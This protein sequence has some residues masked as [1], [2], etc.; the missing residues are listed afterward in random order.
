MTLNRVVFVA[1]LF[2]EDY[3]G[4]A[5]LTS[6][7][8]IQSSPHSVV[9]IKAR[10][11]NVKTLEQYQN[12]YWIFGNFASLDFN[13]IPII[14]ANI[15]YA[16]LEY[17]YKF[18]NFRSVEKHKRASGTDCDCANHDVG[19]YVSSF[20]YAADHIFWMSSGQRDRFHHYF[21]FLAA[22]KQTVLSSVFDQGF[23]NV[24]DAIGNIPQEESRQ[25]W[26]V[27]GSDSW[28]KGKEDA[29]KWCQDNSKD[30]EVIW[31]LPYE[32]VLAK[33]TT[34]EGF[35]YL[36]RGGD[37]CPRMVIEAK[38]LGC[39]VVTNSNVQHESEEWWKGSTDEA[40]DYL[41]QRP[42]VF[43]TTL[44]KYIRRNP[45]ISGY[46]TTYNCVSQGYPFSESITSMLDCLDEVIVVDGGSTD[47]TFEVLQNMQRDHVNLR[48]V[49]NPRD[50]THKR[51]AVFDGDQKSVARSF[52]TGDFCWQMDVDEIIH[53]NDYEKIRNLIRHV[54]K[55]NQLIALP[56]VEFWGK[57]GKVR[58]DIN[59]WKWRLSRNYPHITHGIPSHLRKHD[60]DGH[61]YASLGTDGCDYIHSDTHEPIQF[62]SFHT[63]ETE[64]L[65]QRAQVSEEFR[66]RYVAWLSQ[67]VNNLPGVYHYSWYDIHR[68]M[69]TYRN[70]WTQHWQSLFDITQ[71]DTPENN[72]FF[73]KKWDDVTDE[74]MH[75]LS[76]KLEE[77]MGGWIFHRKIDWN[78][79]TPS[80]FIES[81]KH[82]DI[83][84]DWVD[85]E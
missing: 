29:I 25:G 30:Y 67:V 27:L 75:D 59:P 50:W 49:S 28:I 2:A 12:D 68:K 4:G 16:I 11:V 7:A 43:W 40:R 39:Q 41:K 77:K 81:L 60:A 21:P 61:L 34:A 52:C 32:Q 8:L 62:V 70:Y 26:I 76:K 55:S 23:F 36:P 65:R 38:L 5:E 18:C 20:Y 33:L 83:M 3:A 78:N 72:M 45:S 10:D 57:T 31:D 47:G 19:K 51:F 79:P 64:S 69:K 9:K 24:L 22:R 44:E 73:D 48:V 74:E 1:D 85:D 17:D 15:N 63:Q 54:H 66:E 13:L 14:I 56:V 80:V 35:V 42:M 37:T 82:P 46:T 58:I 53:E 71:E 6:D 84:I